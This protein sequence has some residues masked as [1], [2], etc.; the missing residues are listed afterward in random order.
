MIL[1]SGNYESLVKQVTKHSLKIVIYGVGMIGQIIV[2]FLIKEYSLYKYI[3]CFIDMDERKR[4]QV[5]RIENYQYEIKTPDYLERIDENYVILITNSNFFSVVNFLDS[6]QNLNYVKGYIVPMMQIHE[7]ENSESIMINRLYD[8]QLIPKVIHY[9]WFGKKDKPDF[10]S[11]CIDSWK[12]YCPDYE[13]IEWNEDNYDIGRHSYTKEAY[14]K[15]KYGFVT[16]VAR[17]DILYENGGIYLD[18]DVTLEKSLDDLLYQKGFI[19]T[20]KWG[21]INSGGGCGFVKH[22]PMLKKIIDYR[23][24]FHFVLEDGSLNLDTCGM[25]ETKLFLEAGFKPNNKLQNICDVTIYPSYINHPYDY[26]SCDT[27]K[28]ESTISV[29]HFYGGW[30][31]QE[32]QLNRKRTQVLY[33]KIK[34]RMI[35]NS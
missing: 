20:E 22:H 1:T 26:M 9:S 11:M 24:L 19:G 6:I 2:P 17:L 27:H 5:I 13:I 28:K 8:R 12:R 30:I 4:G 15:E 32:E 34:N 25:Y 16:D 21:N 29:H 31:D 33:N 18:T 23:D 10:L 35:S 7:M 3:D 14:G